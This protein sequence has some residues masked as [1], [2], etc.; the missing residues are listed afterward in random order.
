MT[1]IDEITLDFNAITNFPIIAAKQND[2]DSRI[3]LIHFT[4]NGEAAEIDKNLKVGYRIR[5]PD[6]HIVL[7]NGVNNKDNTVTITLTQEC[8]S[9]AGRAYADVYFHDNGGKLLSTTSFIINIMAS[10]NT[11]TNAAASSDEF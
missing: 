10:P 3:L 6:G 5:K 9:A 11:M 8:L 4:K 1:Y 2:V 7:N